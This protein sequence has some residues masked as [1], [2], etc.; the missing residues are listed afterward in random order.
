MGS[1][2]EE[3]FAG[4][5]YDMSDPYLVEIRTKA[6]KLCKDYNDTYEDE[7]EKRSSILSMLIPNA[8]KNLYLQGP[9]QFDYGIYT[10]FGDYCY[11]NFNFTVLDCNHVTIGN[12]VFF[13]PNV[14]IA[15]PVHPFLPEERNMRTKPDG[16]VYDKEMALPIT[17]GNN[18]WIASNVVIC[19][20]VEIGD[21]CVI[22]AG[23][24]VNRNIPPNSFAAGSPCRVIRQITEADRL[25]IRF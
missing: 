22:G 8:G 13:G 25:N 23:S 20:G 15:P 14:V 1:E 7:T 11:A 9:I 5:P 6:H 2:L 10:T 24:V 16:T 18:C 21:G 12:Q 3:M 19:G 4:R 17:I